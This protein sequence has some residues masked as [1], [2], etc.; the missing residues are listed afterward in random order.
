[1]KTTAKLSEDGTHYV[2]NGAKTFHHRRRPRRPGH[3]ARAP[4]PVGREPPQGHLAARRRHQGAGYAVGRKLDKLGLKTSDT[5]ELSFTDV[6]VPVEDLLGE[7]RVRALLPG[8]NL[9]QERLGIAWA[10]MRR[11]PPRSASPRT[12]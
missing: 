10:P 3:R 6:R 8:R 7:E 9:P 4:L 1:M 2:L 5:A 11:R 12:M